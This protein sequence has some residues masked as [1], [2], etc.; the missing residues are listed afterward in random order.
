MT[1][2]HN[3]NWSA[4]EVMQKIRT[5]NLG[6]IAKQYK[7]EH[8]RPLS[9]RIPPRLPNNRFYVITLHY[10]VQGFLTVRQP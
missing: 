7:V 3:E 1:F 2:T 8:C 10:T 6:V 5:C 4:K 9:Y